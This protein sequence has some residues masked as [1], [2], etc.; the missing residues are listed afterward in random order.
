MEYNHNNDFTIITQ[1]RRVLQN[2]KIAIISKENS[3]HISLVIN[4]LTS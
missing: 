4:F 1:D 3:I 2:I